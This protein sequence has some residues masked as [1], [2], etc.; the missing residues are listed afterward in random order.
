VE[1]RDIFDG[2]C[3]VV[4][5]DGL[6]GNTL[7]KMAEGFAKS[8]INGIVSEI[9]EQ[10]PELM[11]RLEPVLK[12]MFKKLDY[13]EHGGAPLLGV[14]GVCMIAHGSSEAKSIRAALKQCRSYVRADLNH[15]IGAR[16]AELGR[17]MDSVAVTLGGNTQG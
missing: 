7:L 12:G 15:A 9:M 4:V 11:L 17:Q 8:I 14:N 6:V 5:T 10:D 13:H 2:V 1:G 3:D 16:I